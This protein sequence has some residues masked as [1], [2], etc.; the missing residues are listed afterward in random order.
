MDDEQL[1]RR[2]R[3][4]DTVIDMINDMDPDRLQ[5]KDVA[6]RSGVALAT[7]YRYF[8]SKDH[9]LA[10][11]WVAWHGRLTRKV[12]REAG[13]SGPRRKPGGD[14]SSADRV[15]AYVH[16]EIAAFQRHPNFARLICQV[17][18]SSDPFASEELRVISDDSLELLRSMMIGAPS[19]VSRPAAVAINAVLGNCLANWATGRMLINTVYEMTD[20]VI[21]FVLRGY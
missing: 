18:A 4:T 20:D 1:A 11:A 13:G 8:S 5:M 21:R 15:V 14:Q 19:D 3:L 16:R 9:L 17:Q 2:A 6:E 12:R 7:V 10:A